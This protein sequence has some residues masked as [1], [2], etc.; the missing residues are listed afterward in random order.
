M[1]AATSAAAFC[2]FIRCSCNPRVVM[3]TMIGSPAADRT[4]NAF[5]CAASRTR[6]K[7]TNV[8][9]PRVTRKITVNI[10]TRSRT[11]GTWISACRSKL[12]PL[13]MK[14]IGMRKPN[15]IASSLLVIG[16]A[17][18][19]PDEEAHDDAGGEGA[20]AGRRG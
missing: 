1:P 14:K 18:L 15:P 12:M 3:T 13:S 6:R 11:L 9:R 8:G 5:S 4:A 2:G 17:V 19:P 10:G 7:K 16:S 20:R